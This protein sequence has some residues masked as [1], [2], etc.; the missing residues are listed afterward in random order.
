VV[1]SRRSEVKDSHDR[2]ANIDISYL[3]TRM[4]SFGGVTILATNMKHALDPAFLRR[5][6]F[7]IGFGFPGVTERKAI[8]QSVF[9]AAAPRAALDFDRLARF[10]LPGGS[11][12]NA[13][14][15]AAHGAAAEGSA[16]DMPHVLDAI[17]L[18]LHK[19]ERPV[20]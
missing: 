12:F 14:L 2:Y 13:A 5:L 19:L 15:V 9:P 10:A 17:R 11:I 18:E 1:F 3:L 4:E 20:A 6:R 8:W 7:V 16:V